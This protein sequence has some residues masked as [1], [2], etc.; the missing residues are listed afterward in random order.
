MIK[1]K[2]LWNVLQQEICNII[3]NSK[4]DLVFL[5]GE[6]STG[7]SEIGEI[8]KDKIAVLDNYKG[9]FDEI[10]KDKK[11]LVITHKIELLLQAEKN[12]KVVITRTDD[13]YISTDC[14]MDSYGD[15]SNRVFK[16]EP[17]SV[18]LNNSISGNWSELNE[19]YLQEYI[20]T[21]EI[22]NADKCVLET[23]ESFKKI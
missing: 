4:T 8:L 18:F 11:V 10:P 22:N 16:A 14:D 3:L 5:M 21:H 2:K 23:I 6:N 19:A 9:T 15:V 12:T 1:G 7:K 13:L 20:A 17:L